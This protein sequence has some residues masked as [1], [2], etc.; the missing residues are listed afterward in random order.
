MPENP[1]A[2][3]SSMVKLPREKPLYAFCK[4]FISV[5]IL[6]ALSDIS[7]IA[8]LVIS[9]AVLVSP[10]KLFIIAAL[11]SIATCIYSLA[12]IPAVL[13]AS[14]AYCIIVSESCLK[15]VSIPPTNCCCSPYAETACLTIGVIAALVAATAVLIPLTAV[16]PTLTAAP[17]I[18]PIALTALPTPPPIVCKPLP[19]F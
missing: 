19:I 17:P 2:R 7:V 5:P 10:P 16:A 18:V 6:L 4:D 9:A 12:D 11:D 8:I 1:R 15:S 13:Y 14:L 3:L